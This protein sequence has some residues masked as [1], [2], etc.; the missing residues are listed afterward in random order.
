MAL[1]YLSPTLVTLRSD[2]LPESLAI[3]MDTVLLFLALNWVTEGTTSCSFWT[4]EIPLLLL[5]TKVYTCSLFNSNS[6]LDSSPTRI[7]FLSNTLKM[8]PLALEFLPVTNSSFL[9]VT[10]SVS[11]V[12]Y[13]R[14]Y[15][16][17]NIT[18]SV[19]GM[20][21]LPG[22]ADFTSLK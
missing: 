8:G 12:T 13:T 6:V 10:V 16:S 3:K 5:K 4:N 1:V 18:H 11:P 14:R 17:E 9:I 2:T 19:P 20:I 21:Y 7:L 15:V 22:L